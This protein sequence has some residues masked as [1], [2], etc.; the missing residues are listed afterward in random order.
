[1]TDHR[2]SHRPSA[3]VFLTIPG[4]ARSDLAW[5]PRLSQLAAQGQSLRLRHSFPSVTWPAQATMLTGVLPSQHGV[6]AN[7]FYSRET[8]EVEMWTAGNEIIQAPQIWDQIRERRWAIQSAAWFPMLSKRCSADYICMPAPIHQPDGRETP[9]CYSRPD[10]H[11]AELVPTLGHFPLHHFWGPLASIPSS[12][13]IADS[14]IATARKYRP[15][16]W[17]IYLPHL[18]YAAQRTGPG[19]PPALAALG[20]LD[21]VIGQLI[22]EMSAIYDERVM[23]VAASEYVITPVDHVSY[24][25][26]IL[27]QAGLLEVRSADDGEH[28]D[29]AASRAWA[30]VDHQFS[31]VYVQDRDTDVRDEVVRLFDEIDGI[32]MALVGENRGYVGMDHSRSGDVLLISTP[33]SWQAYYWWLDDSRAPSFA[34]TVDIHRKPGYDPVELFFDP[35]TR[36]I[37]RDATLVRGSHGAPAIGETLGVL[38]V[39]GGPRVEQVEIADTQICPLVMSGLQTIAG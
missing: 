4:L 24:P 26:R 7:G 15:Q 16:F 1:M 32:A 33:T 13:W 37:P 20:E 8:G 19:S 39:A 12:K 22:D 31:H 36:S 9:W 38:L 29:I 18:D 3:L 23:W 2:S 35:A 25:N 5:M 30:L 10:G 6:V 27:R 28:L 21:G 11:Y 34:R 17:Y 14:A